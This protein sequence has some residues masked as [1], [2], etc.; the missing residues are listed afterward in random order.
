MKHGVPSG[1]R[2]NFEAACSDA[3]RRRSSEESKHV[4]VENMHFPTEIDVDDDLQDNIH[5]DFKYPEFIKT[6][7]QREEWNSMSELQRYDYERKLEL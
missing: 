6:S 3:S 1:R 7:D 4:V 2:V 5:S